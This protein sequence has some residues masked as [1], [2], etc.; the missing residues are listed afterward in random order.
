MG[1]GKAKNLR[2]IEAGDAADLGRLGVVGHC[3]PIQ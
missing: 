1:R 2:P 3:P